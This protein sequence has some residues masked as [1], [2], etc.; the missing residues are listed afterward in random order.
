MDHA[1]TPGNKAFELKIPV[2][3]WI[4]V[5]GLNPRHAAGVEGEGVVSVDWCIK[6]SVEKNPLC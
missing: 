2:K 5:E 3:D 4:A 6:S 1:K